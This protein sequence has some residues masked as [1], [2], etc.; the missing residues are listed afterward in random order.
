[1]VH[2][3]LIFLKLPILLTSIEQRLQLIRQALLTW[4][5]RNLHNST[6]SHLVWAWA[7][8]WFHT[9]LRVLSEIQQSFWSRRL[10]N[11][12]FN[13]NPCNFWSFNEVCFLLS[14]ATYPASDLSTESDPRKGT[15]WYIR[16]QFVYWVGLGALRKL[17]LRIVLF[18]HH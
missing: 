7:W 1:M 17:Y 2:L 13:R 5:W 12:P 4:T 15:G 6:F 3:I 9:M 18:T 11:S 8:Y 10:N 16:F 14:R